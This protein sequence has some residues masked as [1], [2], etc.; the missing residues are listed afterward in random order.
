V[1]GDSSL[2][3]VFFCK[4]FFF[5]FFNISSAGFLY[6]EEGRAAV[7]AGGTLSHMTTLSLYGTQQESWRRIVSWAA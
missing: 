3:L 1:F 7:W 6:A 2:V 4:T 5:F